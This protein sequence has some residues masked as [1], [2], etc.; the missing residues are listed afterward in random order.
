MA[1]EVATASD[2]DL[3]QIIPI[4]FKAYGGQ[5]EYINAVFPRGLTKDG[6]E[7]TIQRMIFINSVAPTVKW[8]KITDTS[9]GKIIGGAM[10]SLHE[11]AKPQRFP[12]DGPP[13]TWETDLEK[14]YAKALF[15]SLG[16]DEHKYYEEHDLPFMRLAIMV[17]EPEYQRRGAGAELLKSGLNVADKVGAATTLIAS[18][19]GKGLY[20][21]F[22]FTTL[23]ERDLDLPEK[24][25]HKPKYHIWSMVRTSPK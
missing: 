17:V 16:V 25:S 12:L 21:K 5:N 22:G 9:S 3:R 20:E 4:F 19:E 10:W 11:D 23:A 6:E 2:D 13:G 15:D 14:E 8:E 1:Y 7:M 24:F 18:P